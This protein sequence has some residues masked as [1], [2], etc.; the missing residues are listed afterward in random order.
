MPKALTKVVYKPDQASTDEYT[1]IVN[2]DE[3]KRWKAGE[4]VD[5]FNVFHSNQGHQGLLGTPSKQQ[6]DTHFDT[7]NETEVVKIVLGKG[8]MKASDRI[9]SGT[10]QM[11]PAR[12]RGGVDKYDVMP[13]VPRSL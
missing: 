1:L 4:V 6:L 8:E 13:M 11:N 9:E 10:A 7:H 5:S 2:P 3:Y 12:G